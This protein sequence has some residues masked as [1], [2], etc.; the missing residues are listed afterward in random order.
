MSGPLVS[1]RSLA[2]IVDDPEVVV[3]DC[4]WYLGRPERGRDAY[5][6]GHIP[7]ARFAS[8][9]DDLSGP[10]GPGRHPLPTPESFS[11]AMARLGATPRSTVVAYDDCGGAVAA[12]LWWMADQQGLHA[13]VLDG[14]IQ[15]WA[16]A[17]FTVSEGD[18]PPPPQSGATPAPAGPWEGTIDRDGVA[19]RGAE[20]G[21]ID[22]RAP[23]RYRGDE[24]PVDPKAGHIPGAISLPLSG[25]L[26][27]DLTFLPPDA[28]RAKLSSVGLGTVPVIA[29]CGSGVNACHLI[30]AAEVAGLPRP[31]L[32][33]GSWSDW[34]SSDLPVVTRSEPG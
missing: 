4:R 13:A 21:L 16:R 20:V 10:T 5:R 30:L 1:A 25:S 32:Y 15:A 31:T 27:D 19:G 11:R 14:G 23:S 34:S 17:G 29:H 9:D 22:V 33:V 24:E 18:E 12:R 2:A 8:L 26:H 7:G 3:L 6:E 28:L